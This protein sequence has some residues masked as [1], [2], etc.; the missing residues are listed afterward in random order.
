MQRLAVKRIVKETAVLMLATGALDMALFTY[1][2]PFWVACLVTVGI[3]LVADTYY[4][5]H[6]QGGHDDE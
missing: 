6:A 1:N 5:H 4:Q 2:T 3:F